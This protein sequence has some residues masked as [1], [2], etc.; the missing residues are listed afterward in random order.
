[1]S[2][3]EAEGFEEISENLR[4]LKKPL[5]AMAA[6]IG[7]GGIII[8]LIIVFMVNDT[9]DKLEGSTLAN[10]D[11]A[12][13]TLDDLEVMIATTEVE[14]DRMSGNLGTVQA[15]MDFLS[16][17]VKGSGET[18][19]AM[20]NE[21]SVFSILGGD[22]SEY[23]VGLN[24][25]GEDLVESSRGL[26]EVGDSLAGHEEGLAGLK[27]GFATI[28]GDISNQ[29][30]QIASLRSGIESVFGTVK[31]VNILLFFLIVIMLSVP[32]INSMA[33]II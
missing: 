21:L 10:L 31:I 14:V 5:H 12:M 30:A 6:L 24:Q 7:G 8:A 20:G 18:I 11:A 16:E 9:V 23:A 33:G 32:V 17:G 29:K 27:A 15:S 26:R 28:R 2:K 25:S 4:P 13:R 1:M 22:F 3:K 19:G